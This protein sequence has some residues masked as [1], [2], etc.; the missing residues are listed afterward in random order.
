MAE[1]R[2]HHA[3][4]NGSADKRSGKGNGHSPKS[5]GYRGQGRKDSYGKGGKPRN[6]AHASHAG[7]KRYDREKG[8]VENRSDKD[9]HKSDN[10]KA[11][12]GN[13]GRGYAKKGGKGRRK[14]APRALD[15]HRKS[16]R[17][18]TKEKQGWEPQRTRTVKS[19]RDYDKEKVKELVDANHSVYRGELDPRKKKDDERYPRAAAAAAKARANTD[20]GVVVAETEE[21]SAYA[22]TDESSDFREYFERN[23][24]SPARLAA[25]YVTRVVRKRNAFAQEII[26]SRID[27]SH[28]SP[29]DRAFATLLVLGVVSTWGTLDDVINRTV[30]KPSD[31]S[32]DVRDALRIPTYEIIFLGKQPHAAVDQGVELVRA[33]APKASGLG[34]AVLHRILRLK[35]SFP[36]G[37]PKTDVEALARMYAFPKWLA[38]RL[39][40]DLGAQAASALMQA[41]NSPAPIYIAVNAIKATDDEIIN[42]FA[43]AGCTL[44]PATAGDR[45]VPGCYRVVNTRV[46]AD[47][48][49][50]L[51][52]KQ[53]K[54]LVSDAAAQAV[55]S[56]VLEAGKPETLL[57]VGAGRGTKT[58]LLQSMAMRNFDSQLNLT[59]M[60]SHTFK[61]ELLIDRAEQYGV[62][63]NVLKGNAM[64]MDSVVGD[65][66][67]DAIFIDAPCSGL[68]TLRRHQE[69]RWRITETSITELAGNGLAMLRSCASHVK[70]GGQLV[71][72]TCTVTYAENN[73]VVRRFLE[74][75]EGSEFMLAPI[76][77]K[78]CF[79][80]QLVP[81][82][83]DAHFAARFV[84]KA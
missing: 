45:E 64:R 73:D 46:L 3:G 66:M 48:R 72:A 5:S 1:N 30:D 19:K 18:A 80:T 37:D 69:I 35:E 15:K 76:D 33:V 68:G 61:S 60:D 52:F 36:F 59:S 16:D 40:E 79:A 44:Q 42:A 24:A 6:Q 67:Y 38:I 49:I 21:R 8:S 17:I 2:A 14:E 28:L 83:C 32:L 55:A 12:R 58:I 11:H 13:D 47:G 53:G 39:I 56:C 22:R 7:G 9:Q 75:E 54:I 27:N 34:N 65:A 25:L 29:E 41:S 71:Y 82:S 20:D 10:A 31:L 70:P 81:G 62:I 84:R 43:D 51:L 50:R 23:E 4:N 78:S 57:E 26:E 63:T 77:G 74:S